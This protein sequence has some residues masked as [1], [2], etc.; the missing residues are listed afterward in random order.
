[1][2][3]LTNSSAGLNHNSSTYFSGAQVTSA[4]DWVLSFTFSMFLSFQNGCKCCIIFELFSS[5]HMLNPCL[6]YEDNCIYSTFL[7][8]ILEENTGLFNSTHSFPCQGRVFHKMLFKQS[9]CMLNKM[10]I[11]ITTVSFGLSIE[12]FS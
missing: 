1:M 6:Q 3:L 4:E 2:H 11:A 5:S 12:I 8:T 7:S 9:F 10:A